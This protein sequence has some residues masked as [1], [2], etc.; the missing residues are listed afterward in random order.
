MYVCHLRRLRNGKRSAARHK[1]K[2]AQQSAEERAMELAADAA[3]KD[4]AR[5][6]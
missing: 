5:K 1:A 2:L 4:A 3:R 6:E